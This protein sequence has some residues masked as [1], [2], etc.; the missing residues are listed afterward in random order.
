MRR[1]HADLALLAAAAIWGTAFLL[2]KSAMSHVEP[3]TF[4]ASR[5]TVAAL[6][7]APFAVLEA[8]GSRDP[9]GWDFLATAALAGLAFFLAAWPQQAGIR[10]ATVTNAGFLTALYVVITPFLAWGWTGK[11]PAQ[12]IWPAAACSALGT[13]LLGGGTLSAL[14]TGD[15]L[16]ALSAVLWAAQVVITGRASAFRRP[17]GF[18]A[19]Q[20]A[21]VAALAAAGAAAL[22]APTRDGLAGAAFEIAYVGL[23]SSALTFALLT[24]ALQYMPPAE[25]AVIISL[26]TVFAALAGYLFLGERLGAPGLAGAGLILLGVLCIQLG[27]P[28]AARQGR[29]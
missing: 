1:L 21:V 25:A 17:I 12:M 5:C 3:L 20:L 26:D 8:R 14:S 22:E 24:I 16:I 13:W 23:L 6:A 28:L 9:I 7:L 2:Q 19:V 10:T 4:V 11:R 15:R 29:G 18:T 27:P